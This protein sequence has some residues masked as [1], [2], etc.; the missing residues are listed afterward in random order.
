[1]DESRGG[2]STRTRTM[3]ETVTSR[4]II[5]RFKDDEI[6]EGHAPDLDLDRPDFVLRVTDPGS[7][8]RQSIIPIGPVKSL[9]LERRELDVEPDTAQLK[10]G[11]IRFRD[12]EVRNG[13]VGEEPGQSTSR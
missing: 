9:L 6:M 12:S 2:M 7:N 5:V 11:A 8:N 4:R 10:K 13:F 3:R 1:M